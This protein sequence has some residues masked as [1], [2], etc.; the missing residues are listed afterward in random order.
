[1]D[2]IAFTSGLSNLDVETNYRFVSL[3]SAAFFAFIKLVLGKRG[4]VDWY[5]VVH[6]FIATVG[7]TLCLVIDFYADSI[8]PGVL[9]TI[10]IL[11]TV[12]VV[13][14]F[15]LLPRWYWR[16]TASYSV[17]KRLDTHS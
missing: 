17:F 12:P 4:G 7:S 8:D 1:M 3:I 6:A 5:A 2:I 16:T 11:C 13:S 15:T 9:N 10:S 14:P